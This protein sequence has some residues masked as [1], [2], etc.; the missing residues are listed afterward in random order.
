[1]YALPPWPPVDV[2]LGARYVKRVVGL[3]A[4]GLPMALGFASMAASRGGTFAWMCAPLVAGGLFLTVLLPI[5][6]RGWVRRF[7]ASGV[8]LFNGRRFGWKD[9]AHVREVWVGGVRPTRTSRSAS[10]TE[11]GS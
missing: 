4:L 5:V 8:T 7:D 9:L 11:G 10:S 3:A 1:M 6:K 2:E